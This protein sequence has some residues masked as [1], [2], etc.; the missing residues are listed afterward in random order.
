[1]NYLNYKHYVTI[2]ESYKYVLW[3]IIFIMLYNIRLYKIYLVGRITG[4]WN[5]VWEGDCYAI[6][7]WVFSK[8]WLIITQS[9]TF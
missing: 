5:E 7:I 2:L 1:M 8:N 6:F 3:F 9:I 4:V